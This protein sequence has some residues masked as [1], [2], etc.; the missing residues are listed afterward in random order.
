MTI[1]QWPL[2]THIYIYIYIYKYTYRYIYAYIYGVNEIMCPP[3][4]YESTNG[5]MAN[6]N[7][8][9]ITYNK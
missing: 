6:G 7:S 2:I 8:C 1:D 3:G 4:Y 5:L 9:T